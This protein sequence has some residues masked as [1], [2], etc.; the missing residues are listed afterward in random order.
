MSTSSDFIQTFIERDIS[1]YSVD[2]PIQSLTSKKQFNGQLPA[3][4]TPK[5]R[6]SERMNPGMM[7]M[8]K[9]QSICFNDALSRVPFYERSFNYTQPLRKI[10]NLD[11]DPRY[12][13]I[14]KN[15]S[16]DYSQAI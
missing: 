14:T 16:S 6:N 4:T 12:G 8:F 11:Q 2:R 3:S 1:K 7:T 10:P 15:F 13:L 9:G 5:V